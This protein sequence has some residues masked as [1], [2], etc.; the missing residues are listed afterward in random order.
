MRR[1]QHRG[2]FRRRNW[3]LYA[4]VLAVVIA[5]AVAVSYLPL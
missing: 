1:L 4:V 5:A 3:L 2:H